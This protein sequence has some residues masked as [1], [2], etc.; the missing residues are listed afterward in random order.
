MFDQ[1]RIKEAFATLVGLRQNNNPDFGDLS[2]SLLYTGDNVLLSHPLCTIENLDMCARNYGKY[3][4]PTWSNV[5]AYTTGTRVTHLTINYEALTN[6]TGSTPASNPTDWKV[7]N[8]LD[9]FLQ[10]RNQTAA[11]AKYVSK[12]NGAKIA[13]SK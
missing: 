13:F 5:T 1:K 6:S 11:A 10:K 3:V 4:F 12:T 2:P 9:L 7:L 8:L